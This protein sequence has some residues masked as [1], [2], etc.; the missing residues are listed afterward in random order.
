[1]II[2]LMWCVCLCHVCAV[3]SCY[4]SLGDG[5]RMIVLLSGCQCHMSGEASSI[6]SSNGPY[7]SPKKQGVTGTQSRRGGGLLSSPLVFVLLRQWPASGSLQPPSGQFSE[8]REE[9]VH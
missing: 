3:L 1:M 6:L 9:E 5:L 8:P 4:S 2:L 7:L